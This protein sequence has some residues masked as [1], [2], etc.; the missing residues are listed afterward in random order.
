MSRSDHLEVALAA[1]SRAPREGR[2]HVHAFLDAQGLNRQ[3]GEAALV[4]AS[5][6]VTNAV[7]HASAPIRL[8]I[9]VR[10]H[11][12]QLA[13]HDGDASAA[14][15]AIPR[16]GRGDI[17]GRGLELVASLARCWGVQADTN[18]KHV[19]AEIDVPLREPDHLRVS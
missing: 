2:D 11:T 17:S 10:D 15:V 9:T 16:A 18:G 7:V 12:L 5:E 8:D 19:W 13:V 6:L 14:V 4:I 1:G 3:V